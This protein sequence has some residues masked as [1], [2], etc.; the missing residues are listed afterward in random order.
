[1]LLG[2]LLFLF[3][4]IF[5]GTF[6]GLTPGI[7]INLISSIIISLSLTNFYNIN[8]IFLI[9]F[10][11][12]MSITHTFVDFIPSI[13]LGAPDEETML[14]T[15]PGHKMLN[16]GMG[17]EAVMLS[18]YGGII[19]LVLLIILLI[20]SIKLIPIIYP[21]LTKI[22]APILIII[23]IKLILSDKKRIL[24]LIVFIL[25]GILG[26]IVFAIDENILSQPLMPLLTGLFGTSMLITSIRQKTKIK[27]QK[28]TKNIKFNF[29]SPVIGS[30]I[31][32]PIC[33]FL[34]G[35]GSGQASILGDQISKN[36][37]RGF[38][39]L[40]GITNTLVMG[41][42]FI[43]LYTI[44]KAR[45]GS[46]LAIQ[47]LSGS[48]NLNIFVIILIT[49]II[50]GFFSFYITKNLAIIFSNNI[51]KIDYSKLSIVIIILTTLIVFIFSGFIGLL[52]LIIST[53]TGIYSISLGVRRTNMMG[54]IM[55]PTII[56]YLTL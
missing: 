43:S 6:S 20:P 23:T 16:K 29:K 14:S 18:N 3:L 55:L 11:T 15:L 25:T 52:V 28:I 50:S 33:G 17:Y 39:V 2:I 1:M 36:D 49:I 32:S 38:I 40:N 22:M 12:S 56:I 5:A 54:C 51:T 27:N 34:P 53:L 4:G 42:S 8:N 47:D 35:L 31:A 46:A 41:I 48:I 10:I 44:N 26:Y 13:F 45:T 37:D 21:K 19:A 9:I 30:L 24:S 7:H